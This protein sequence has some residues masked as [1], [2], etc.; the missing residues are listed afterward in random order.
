ML[1]GMSNS[2]PCLAALLV[3][4]GLAVLTVSPALAQKPAETNKP[5]VTE[6]EAAAPKDVRAGDKAYEQSRRLLSA[7]DTI[8]TRAA[9]ERSEASGLPSREKFVIPPLWTET[10]ED[11]EQ[12]IRELL[13]SAL[14]IVS[15]AP[16]VEM[17]QKIQTRRKNIGSIR[18]EIA[19]L[20][21]KRLQAPESGLLPGLLSE[22]QGSIDDSIVSLQATIKVNEDE[23]KGIKGEIG[24]SL[25]AAGVDV[26]PEQLDLLLDSVLGSDLLKL[27]TAFEA[28]RAIDQRLGELLSQSGEDVK[29]ARRYFAMHAALFAMLLQAQDTLI[30]KIDNDYLAKLKAVLA[31][32]KRTRDET[33][34]LLA[35]QNRPDQRHALEA[36]LK[37]QELSEKVASFYRDYLLTQR[38]QLADARL[39]TL[40]DLRIADNTFETVQASFELRALMDD[41]RTSFEAL[42][43]L[44]APGFD[45]V[46]K[47]ENLRKEFESLTE[48]LGPSS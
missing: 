33:Y 28:S 2:R 44:E 18:D 16:I 11:R 38:R 34:A 1:N 12:T 6:K 25:K 13:D 19:R 10:R 17:Q 35:G 9:E 41:A 47:N 37:S 31:D 23:I 29:T 21:E 22:T 27:V 46:F 7:I 48:K 32:I 43:R 26:S 39:R 8:L 40:R 24:A 20:R 4:L 3:V 15:D 30:D 14:E 45:Q 5:A 36:N 42:Q